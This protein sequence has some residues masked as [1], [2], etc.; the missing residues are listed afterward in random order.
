MMMRIKGEL[1][2]FFLFKLGERVMERVCKIEEKEGK[3]R[4]RKSV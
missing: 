4:E 3:R 1:F 2:N